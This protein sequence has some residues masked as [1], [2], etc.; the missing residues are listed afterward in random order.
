M[1]NSKKIMNCQNL[2]TKSWQEYVA[3][4]SKF[5]MIYVYGLIGLIPIAAVSLVATLV[6]VTG[7]WSKMPFMAQISLGIIFG[8]VVICS[9]IFAIY[10]GLRVKVATLLLIKNNYS[11][12]ALN[13]KDSKNY[14]WGMLGV[15]LLMFVVVLAWGFVFLIPAII[16][17]VYYMFAAYI[18]VIE[19]KRSFSAMERSYDLVYGFWW[20]V[21]GRMLLLGLIGLI[22][23]MIL[24]WP[25]NFMT[26]GSAPFTLYNIIVNVIWMAISPYFVVYY[27]NIYKSLNEQNK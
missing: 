11:D 5:I 23:F 8:L 20:P 1:E 15:S 2:L 6:I 14:V 25:L 16:F 18:L 17:G 9:I 22:F 24:S 19:N 26:E 3:N 10:Y 12:T 4:F 13:F 7:V 27:Y 21:F